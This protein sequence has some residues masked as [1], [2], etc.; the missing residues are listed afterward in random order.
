MPV[1]SRATA[2]KLGY[3]KSAEK[4]A[5]LNKR[6]RRLAEQ[7]AAGKRCRLCALKIPYAKRRNDFCSRSCAASFN[8]SGVVRSKAG[9]PSQ[10]PCGHGLRPGRRFCSGACGATAKALNL[11]DRWLRGL[12]TGGTWR[13]VAPYV[14]RW[15]TQTAGENCSQCGWAEVH[16]VTG[17][18]P[19]HVDHIDGNPENHRPT[20]LRF[21]CPNCHSLTPT[22]GGLNRGRGRKQRYAGV[23]QRQ[24]PTLV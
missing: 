13:G 21:L 3:A 1:H 20:N 19:L 23:A 22:F 2:G 16:S 6:K 14:R 5:V 24:S 17:K 18:I 10:C 15:L 9:M 11:M 12:E 4:L 8:N 7:H